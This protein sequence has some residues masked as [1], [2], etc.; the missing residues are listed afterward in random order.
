ML[1]HNIRSVANLSVF[2]LSDVLLS[3][4]ILSVVILSGIIQSFLILSGVKLSDQSC[5]NAL[6]YSTKVHRQSECL[7]TECTEF[8][9]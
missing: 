1:S 4:I 9:T 2:V 3:D 5:P 8:Y 6:A 7:C